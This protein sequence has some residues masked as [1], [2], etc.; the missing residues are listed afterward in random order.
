MKKRVAAIISEYW[1]ISHADVIITKM[2]D[3]FS[4]DGRTYQSTLDI[5]SMYV[6]RFPDNDMSRNLAAKH[7]IPIYGSI[8]EA[9]LHGGDAFTLDGIILI[10]EHGVYPFN[11]IGQELYPRRLFFE[12]C[13]NV[14]LEYNRI[15]PV[16]TDKGFAVVQEDI[17]W[18]YAQIKRYDIPFMSSSVVPFA[19]KQPI[20]RPFPP[21]APLHK[22]FGFSYGSLERYVYHT[23]EM[24]QSVAEQ[25]ACG[26][27]GIRAVRAYKNEQ[28]VSRLLSDEW[29]AIYRA[30]G[31]FINLRDVNK[32]PYELQE[33]VFF[34]LDYVDGLQ[35]G[36]LYCDWLASKEMQT[37]A[38]AY[39]VLE[40]EEP[41][42]VEFWLQNQK[43]YSHFGRLTLEIEKFIHTR[44][45]PFPVERSLLTTGGLDA[46]MRSH[47]SGEEIETPHLQV[48]Y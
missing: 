43:P 4:L 46:C 6:D 41:I 39:Q 25:R 5:V 11:E 30:C 28:A 9:L 32:F 24:L 7:S 1:D 13:L 18:M 44:R 17:E 33:P 8:R 14:M 34:E 38:S 15:V 45:P 48:R 36:V 2:L 22:M 19:R 42:C 47:Y 16:Y 35:S 20:E 40:Q 10:G 23:L 37:F 21:G 31:G 29:G 26:E 27:S 12:A 3:G